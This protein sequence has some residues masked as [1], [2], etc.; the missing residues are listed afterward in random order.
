ME[1]KAIIDISHNNG[2]IDWSKVPVDYVYIK[3]N[4]GVGCTDPMFIKNASQAIQHGKKIGYYHFNSLNSKDVVNDATSEAKEFLS[5]IT[6]SP[7]PVPYLPYILDIE[8]NKIELNKNEVLLWIKTFFAELKNEGI[9]DVAIYS[10]ASFLN[11]NLPAN[12]DLGG[13]KLWLAGY[14]PEQRLILPI[15]WKSYWMWQ[16]TQSGTCPGITGNVDISKF[17]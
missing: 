10:Y 12:H 16:Y 6:K 15:G 5:L 8:T 1:N 4:E 7:N 9:V 2:I 13:I 14:V 11:E 3:V 17:K